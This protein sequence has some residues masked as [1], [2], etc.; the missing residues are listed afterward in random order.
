MVE[1]NPHTFSKLSTGT[2]TQLEDEVDYPH[3]GLFKALVQMSKGNIVIKNDTNDFDITQASSGNVIQV[4]AGTY[5]RDGK[6]FTANAANFTTSAFTTTYDKGYHMLVVNSSNT[7]AIRQ[8]TA[9]D[10]VPN[11]TTGDTIIALIEI[12]STTSYGSRLIQFLTTEK[13]SNSVNIGYDNSG[14]TEAMSIEGSAT[15]TLFKNRVADADIRFVLADN[16][17]DEK[18]EIYSDDDSDGDE[19]D[20]EIFSVDGTGVT[21]VKS[22]SLGTAAE[23]T[24]TESSDDITIKNTVSDKDI[25]FNINDGGSDTEVMRIDGST[26]RVGVGTNAPEG[27]LE[28]EHTTTT[29]HALKVFRN[30]SASNMDSSLVLL[31][32]D[33]QYTDETTLHIKQDGTG[34]GLHVQVAG[35]GDAIIVESTDADASAA[36][37]IVLYRNSGSSPADGDD[38][39]HLLIRGRNFDGSSTYADFRYADQFWEIVDVTTGTEDSQTAMRIRKNGNLEYRLRLTPDGNL[40]NG[41][42]SYTGSVM[43]SLQVN[44]KGADNDNGIIVVRDDGTT[45]SGDALGGIGF[46]SSDG[47]IPSEIDEASA[48]ILAFAT[49]D[50]SAGDK[51]GELKMGI[52]RINSN[53]DQEGLVLSRIGYPSSSTGVTAYVGAFSRAAV[54]VVTNNTYSPTIQDSGTVIIMNDSASIVVLPDVSVNEIGVQFTIINNSGGTLTGKIQSADTSNTRFNGAGSYAAQNIDDDKAK[55]FICW[56]ADNWQVIG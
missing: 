27:V 12:T 31:H 50:H 36:P 56:A 49:E 43:N 6:L 39:A 44:H 18:F 22:L 8:P 17:A 4:S 34:K 33:S 15:R 11:Y 55:T 52:S 35:T 48:F 3:S 7:L 24:I 19:G 2:L 51:G 26:S 54:A 29:G 41:D 25:I 53:D 14:Y 21:K 46:D 38:L 32:D 23:L 42:A 47:N 37:D 16:T 9:A 1:N 10:R 28:I 40:I 30:Q 20:T 13:T 45:A 5:F